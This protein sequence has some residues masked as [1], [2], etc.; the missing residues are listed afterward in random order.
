MTLFEKLAAAT[1]EEDVKAA[2]YTPLH[3]VD[4]AYDLLSQTLCANWQRDYVVWDMCCGVGNLETKHGNARN[5]FMSTLDQPD[6]DVMKAAN[7]HYAPCLQRLA[8]TVRN[9]GNDKNLQTR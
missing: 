1:R 6:V 2:Y 7:I 4:K 8:N 9:S 5:V 3:V